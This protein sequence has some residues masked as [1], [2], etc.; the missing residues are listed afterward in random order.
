MGSGSGSV[1]SGSPSGPTVVITGAV[2]ITEAVVR[3]AKKFFLVLTNK[4]SNYSRG[5][6]GMDTVVPASVVPATVVSATVVPATVV[7][8]TVVSPATVVPA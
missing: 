5:A 4:E 3:A 1:G 2:G 8:A 6:V 7:S